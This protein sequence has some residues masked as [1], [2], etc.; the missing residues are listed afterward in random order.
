YRSISKLLSLFLMFAACV[1]Y[2]HGTVTAE[3]LGTPSQINAREHQRQLY[4]I[5][6]GGTLTNVKCWIN[7]LIPD[8]GD[9]APLGSIACSV[10][11]KIDVGKIEQITLNV[12]ADQKLKR[13]SYTATLQVLG[14]DP[15]G[16]AVSQ[17]G[18]F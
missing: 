15:S 7:A 9:P 4:V 16:S 2:A 17:T 18:T 11:E 13:G 14:L 3:I 12:N 5:A 8:R 10:S 6:K 1:Q